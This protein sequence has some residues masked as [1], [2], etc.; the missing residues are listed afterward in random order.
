MPLFTITSVVDDADLKVSHILRGDDHITNT[1][2]QIKLFQYL[3]SKIPNFA[4][5]PLMRTKTGSGLSKRFNSFSLK[6]LKKKNILP[7]IIVNY[8]SKIGSSL[9]IDNSQSLESLI[10]TFKV[11]K[12]SKNSVLFNEDDLARLNSKNLK[13]LS[14]QDIKKNFGFDCDEKF[15]E[16]IRGNIE[17]LDEIYEWHDIIS[18]GVKEK[19][20]IDKNLYDLIKANIPDKIDLQSWQIWTKSVLEKTEIKPKDLFIKIRMLLTGKNLDQV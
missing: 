5:F 13:E 3:G 4:H 15:W 12:F 8:L 11:N 7:I 18:K 1:A 10:K 16:I 20:I 14:L 2:A 17:H 9:S 6:E 19:V